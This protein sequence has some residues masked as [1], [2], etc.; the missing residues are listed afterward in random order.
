[1]VA[2]LVLFGVIASAV[3]LLIV[4]L[5][6]RGSGPTGNGDGLLMEQERRDQAYRDRVSFSSVAQHSSLPTI[7]DHHHRRR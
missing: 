5:L 4:T 3:V 7:G 6:R 2:V 1:M